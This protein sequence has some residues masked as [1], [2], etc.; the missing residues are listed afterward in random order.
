M[1]AVHAYPE[2]TTLGYASLAQS[3]QCSLYGCISGRG[4]VCQFVRWIVNQCCGHVW[5]Y[6][7]PQQ[8]RH[9]PDH[10]ERVKGFIHNIYS[11]PIDTT[12][13]CTYCELFMPLLQ[14]C[15]A[16]L[17]FG[18]CSCNRYPWASDLHE[19]CRYAHLIDKIL[20]LDMYMCVCACFAL[21]PRL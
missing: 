7:L 5:L 18:T 10:R 15:I 16:R 14:I 11:R 21:I 9:I 19:Y 2:Y 20:Q 1:P 12:Q 17:M 4:R 8:F 6:L 3:H 13:A